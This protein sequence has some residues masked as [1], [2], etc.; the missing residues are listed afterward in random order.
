[1]DY[2]V[3]VDVSQDILLTQLIKFVTNVHQTNIMILLPKLVVRAQQAHH[4]VHIQMEYSKYV[5][6]VQVIP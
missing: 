2:S 6:A 4:A 3:S 1:M 5:D